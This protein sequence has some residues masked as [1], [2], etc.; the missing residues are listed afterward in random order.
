MVIEH[1]EAYVFIFASPN[2]NICIYNFMIKVLQE[3]NYKFI[4][5]KC[6][7]NVSLCHLNNCQD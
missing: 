3:N 5:I 7:Q 4:M 2:I 1:I 6:I